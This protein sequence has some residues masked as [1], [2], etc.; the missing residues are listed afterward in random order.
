MAG[1]AMASVIP[2][3]PQALEARQGPNTVYDQYP[4]DQTAALNL[5]A[6][7]A[8]APKAQVQKL[9]GSRTLLRPT[10]LPKGFKLGADEHPLLFISG[11]FTDIRQYNALSIPQL[12]V[13]HLYIPYT[14]GVESSST[15]FSYHVKT[16]FDQLIP[17]LVGTLLQDSN[18]Y[19]ANFDPPHAA[20]KPIGTSSY[21]F[22]VDVGLLNVIDGPGITTPAFISYFERSKDTSLTI[23]YLKSVLN[24]PVI[25]TSSNSCNKIIYSFN[26]PF[27][28]PFT[29]KGSLKSG[30]VLSGS[31]LSFSNIEGFSGTAQWVLPTAADPCSK[32]A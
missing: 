9:V 16:Y 28:D 6:W 2:Q 31:A 11:Y 23:D 32:Y 29:V 17:S 15:P 20:F 14:Q 4:N 5:T 7:F 30:A 12:S 25:R 18:S 8:P 13:Q 27:A 10:D 24:Q 21:T 26:E 19:P 1:V 3:V 22:N